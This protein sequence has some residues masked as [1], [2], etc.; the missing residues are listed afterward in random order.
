SRLSPDAAEWAR[1]TLG[2]DFARLREDGVILTRS[3]TALEEAVKAGE[4]I[5]RRGVVSLGDRCRITAPAVPP[6]VETPTGNP[7]GRLW[8]GGTVPKNDRHPR[9]LYL[10]LEIRVRSDGP[11]RSGDAPR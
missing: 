7:V 4:V 9:A 2:L 3:R 10:P 11:P 1:E 5:R 6:N 8:G